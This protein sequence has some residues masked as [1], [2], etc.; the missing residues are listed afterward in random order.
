[1]SSVS[2]CVDIYQKCKSVELGYQLIDTITQIQSD[3]CDTVELGRVKINKKWGVGS[4]GL[5]MM[6]GRDP[7][8]AFEVTK[9]SRGMGENMWVAGLEVRSVSDVF[10]SV[11]QSISY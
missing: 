4:C 3:C 7:V 10:C 6:H 5:S 11:Q 9:T 8:R 1:M 2:L